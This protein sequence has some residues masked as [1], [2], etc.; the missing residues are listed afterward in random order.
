MSAKQKTKQRDLSSDSSKSGSSKNDS[1]VGDVKDT[2]PASDK[3]FNKY[4]MAA[5]IV[6]TVL[7]E[8]LAELK[9]DAEIGQLCSRGDAR[10]LELTSNLFKREKN[11][12]KG[13]AMPTC[14]SIDNCVCHFSPLRSE[15]PVLLKEGQVVKVDLGAHVDGYIATAAHTVVIGANRDNKVTGKKAN[16]IVSAYN[17]MEMVLR[18]LKPEKNLKNVEISEKMGKLAKIYETT[19][20]ENMLSHN[21]ERFKPVGDK[22]II[23]N[24]GDEQK[25]KSEKCTFETFEVYTIDVLISTGEAMPTCISIDN[26]VCHFSPLRSEPP[27]LLKEGQVVKVDLGAH[28]DGY[29]AT[30]A[31]TVVIG[32]NRTP[33]ENML[34]HNIERFKPVGDKQIIQNPGDEQKSKS[35]KCTFETFEV[36]TI[37]VLISTGVLNPPSRLLARKS[38]TL[39]ARTTIFKKTDDMVYNLKLK[40]SRAFFHEAQQKFGSMPF[41]IRDFEDEKV[42]KVGSTEC[43]KHDLMQPYPVL[44]EKE[45]DYVAQF[46]CTAIIMPNGIYKITGIPLDNAILKCDVKIDNN[47][48]LGLLNE[49]LKPKKKK[50]GVGEKEKEVNNKEIENNLVK[51]KKKEEVEK[52]VETKKEEKKENKGEKLEVKKEMP[53]KKNVEN[54]QKKKEG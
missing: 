48:F 17:V 36:Y 45:G 47:E 7:K 42:A 23:Q 22:Q 18:M 16:V 4:G 6:N 31:H 30:A 40:A 41:S 11:V 20:I 21:I 44:Y 49:P 2:S 39:D 43:A 50:G 35:E 27:V 19:P 33:I 5:E 10:I 34:S 38:K 15:P 24:P 29:I 28:V 3:V 26:C 54:K 13:I 8:I 53:K 52:N 12:Q 37:D 14:I 32:A 9:V 46:K 1:S 25:S 51:E